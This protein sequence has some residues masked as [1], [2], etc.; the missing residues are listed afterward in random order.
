MFLW[1]DDM[2]KRDDMGEP[3]AQW[4]IKGSVQTPLAFFAVKKCMWKY[5]P[6][7]ETLKI[8]SIAQLT[9]KFV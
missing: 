3:L 8:I 5:P 1:Q 6:Q 9:N 2:K 4:H 7:G